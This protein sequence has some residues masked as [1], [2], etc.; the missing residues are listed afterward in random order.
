MCFKLGLRQGP[1]NVYGRDGKFRATFK[2]ICNYIFEK[3]ARGDTPDPCNWEGGKP[4][5]SEPPFS[6]RSSFHLLR[7]SVAAVW[8]SF[9]H[10]TE[11]RRLSWPESN[12]AV[13]ARSL[14]FVCDIDKLVNNCN[15]LDS[16]SWCKQQLQYWS[17]SLMY[18]SQLL[19]RSL[20]RCVVSNESARQQLN[21]TELT[22]VCSGVVYNWLY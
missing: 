1:W 8:Y 6:M 18:W 4:N 20:C 22:A 2:R 17:M 7:A 19:W 10:P 11:S 21:L 16:Q 5:S 15:E 13:N 3:F 12:N 9:Y 14:Y